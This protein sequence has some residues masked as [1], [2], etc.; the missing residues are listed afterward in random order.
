MGKQCWSQ[1]VLV[2]GS[3]GHSVLQTAALVYFAFISGGEVLYLRDILQEQT[4][5]KSDVGWSCW[6]FLWSKIFWFELQVVWYIPIHWIS[7]VGKKIGLYIIYL[8]NLVCY[9]H[10]QLKMIFFNP[11]KKS[12]RCQ[13]SQPALYR[14]LIQ[15]WNSLCWQVD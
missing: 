4:W 8:P 7:G 9:C 5:L 15:R 11:R 14:H 6:N 1:A 10:R 3:W 13:N 2:S 12:G